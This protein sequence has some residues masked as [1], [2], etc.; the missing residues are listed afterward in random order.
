M[1]SSSNSW[2]VEITSPVAA[3]RLFRAAVMD[4]HTLAP[5]LA[6]HA[7]ASAH[8]VQGDACV[9]SVRRFDFTSAM[10]FGFVKERL[11]FLTADKGECRSTIVEGGGIGVVIETATSHI[12]VEPTADG[13]SAVKV[14]SAYKLMP[15]VEAEDEIARAKD[16]VTAIFKA[17]EAYLVANPDAYS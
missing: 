16:S 6:S 4:W 3:Q 15:G 17:A 8:I 5:K 9:G 11:E 10:P 1:A 2:T 7:V 13:G 12:K 14:S